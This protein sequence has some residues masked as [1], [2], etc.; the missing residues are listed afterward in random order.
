MSNSIPISIVAD[1]LT[2]GNEVYQII[3]KEGSPS[4][5][6]TLRVIQMMTITDSSLPTTTLATTTLATTTT[7][8]ATTTLATTTTLAPEDLYWFHTGEA[9]WPYSKDLMS[10]DPQYFPPDG[11]N[12]SNSTPKFK[13]TFADMLTNPSGYETVNA[14]QQFNTG[15]QLAFDASIGSSYYWILIPDSMGIPDLTQTAGLADTQNNTSDVAHSKMAMEVGGN[16]YTLYR[17]N[18]LSSTSAVTIEYTL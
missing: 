10:N 18:L 5:P 12:Q 3:V 13:Q 8:L 1:S 16:P 6:G 4:N 2:E 14:T 17:V 15:T 11:T 9:T 7:T